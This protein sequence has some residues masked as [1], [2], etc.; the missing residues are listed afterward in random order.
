MWRYLARST[1]F[2]EVHASESMVVDRWKDPKLARLL[3]ER[4]RHV[5]SWPHPI[6][7]TPAVCALPDFP[8]SLRAGFEVR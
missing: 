2:R 7:N 5:P 6:G 8:P 4:G 3:P 1:I